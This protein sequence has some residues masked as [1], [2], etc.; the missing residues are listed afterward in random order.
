M[1]EVQPWSN[2]M[3]EAAAMSRETDHELGIYCGMNAEQADAF[4]QLYQGKIFIPT[5]SRRLSV[6]GW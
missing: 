4:T 6:M 3:G 1:P 2:E 5:G